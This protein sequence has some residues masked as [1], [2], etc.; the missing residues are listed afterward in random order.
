MRGYGA[1]PVT[2]TA[3]QS[4]ANTELTGGP[5][6]L[7]GWSLNDGTADQG[8]TANGQQT[9]PPAGTT[10]ASISLPNGNFTIEWSLELS[11]TP[12]AGDVNNVALFIGATQIAT[13]VNLGAGGIYVQPNQIANVTGGPLTLAAKSIGNGVAGSVYTIV[14]TIIPLG[15][16]QATIFDGGQPVG[17]AT[18]DEGSSTTQWLG[19]YG[20]AVRTKLSVKATQ[21]TATGV[22]YV[23]D[24]YGKEEP[25]RVEPPKG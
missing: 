11:G 16:S 9:A 18:M 4:V 23:V 13:S 15:K 7:V 19:D 24:V 12:G 10:I 5:V 25:E 8:L 22:L 3:G 17:F 21:G 6:R 20:V 1:R 2:V 14:L